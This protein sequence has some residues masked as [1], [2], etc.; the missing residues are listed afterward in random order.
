MKENSLAELFNKNLTRYQKQINVFV[1]QVCVG[2]GIMG[3]AMLALLKA[4]NVLANAT[5]LNIRNFA[6]FSVAG[7]LVPVISYLIFAK[8]KHRKVYVSIFKYI[9]ITCSYFNYYSLAINIPYREI[10]ATIFFA[11]FISTFYLDLNSVLYSIALSIA[12]CTLLFFT[13]PYFMPEANASSELVLRG[14]ALSFGAA[15]ALITALLSKKLLMGSSS[16]ELNVNKS[17][18][19]L[20]AV[21]DKASQISKSLSF[22]GEQIASLATQQNASCEVMSKNSLEV[23]DGAVQT[24]SSVKESSEL[25]NALVD[26]IEDVMNKAD[27]SIK[28]SNELMEDANEGKLLVVSAAEKMMN[29][30]ESVTATSKS[31]K[32]LDS[33]AKEIN[34]IVDFIKQIADQTNLL[35]L[36]A[37]IEAARSGKNGRE[38]AVV[39]DEIRKLAEQSH[40]SLKTINS[41][42]NEILHHSKR[43]D[44]LMGTSVSIVEDGVLTVNRSS[45]YYQKIINKFSLAIDSLSEIS[46]LSKDELDESRK[47][48]VFIEKVDSIASNTSQ[49]LEWMAA[50]TQENLAASEELEKAA[51]TISEMSKELDMIITSN[52]PDA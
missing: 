46:Q 1:L 38:F 33:K 35:S 49:N 16:N 25:L 7:T 4:T 28:I 9:L 42:L 52:T 14:I 27:Y 44:A 32:E 21:F 39:A 10:W 19:T 51:Q 43:V 30:K 5:W 17:L 34:G 20:Q 12:T 3:T 48:K 22:S 31:T 37:S 15:S 40:E 36:N 6:L 50:S 8:G 2:G 23:S 26:G 47:V 18:A 13:N 24:A 11:F 45:E 41:T 29:I